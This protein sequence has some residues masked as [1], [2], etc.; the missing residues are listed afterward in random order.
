MKRV[1]KATFIAMLTWA[2]VLPAL[3]AEK[4]SN[5]TG[6]K[7]RGG[8]DFESTSAII[9]VTGVRL[10][11]NPDNFTKDLSVAEGA[12]VK[13]TARD[14]KARE[15]KTEAF[16]RNNKK[17]GGQ[18]QYYTADFGVDL[19]TSYTITMTFKNGTVLRVE[20]YTLP[21]SWKTHFYFHSTNGT[22]SPASVLRFV[23]DA[24]TKLR[25]CVYAVYPLDNYRKLGGR[26]L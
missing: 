10:D 15:K 4:T 24:K 8:L 12:V 14:G 6:K 16:S 22:K 11:E 19:E 1:I 21:K 26:Q 5:P 25:C 3:A 9:V 7:G 20:D 2:I 18:E 23:E 13:V 17:G